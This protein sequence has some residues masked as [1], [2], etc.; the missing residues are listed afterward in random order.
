MNIMLTVLLI[1]MLSSFI[2]AE[3]NTFEEVYKWKV[4]KFK[5]KTETECRSCIP[6]GIKIYNSTKIFVSFPR[7]NTGVPST[8]ALIDTSNPNDKSPL[9]IPWPSLEMNKEGQYD[10][11]LQLVLGFEIM[12]DK[13][14]ALDQG[15]KDNNEQKG[16]KLMIFNI[17]NATLIKKI[18]LTPYVDKDATFLNDIVIHY[19]LKKAFISDSGN[20]I[21]E[22]KPHKPKILII[23]LDKKEDQ[24][25]VIKDQLGS[26]MMPD[27]AF[28]LHVDGNKVKE[29]SPMKTGIDGIAL[30]CDGSTLFYTPLSSRLLY[31]VKTDDLLNSK[32]NTIAYTPHYKKTASDGL[33]ATGKGLLYMT[34]IEDNSIYQTPIA[35]ALTK[36]FDYTK[37]TIYK[38]NKTHMWPDTLSIYDN[39]LYF[40]ANQLNNFLQNKIDFD[41]PDFNFKIHKFL[42]N[43]YSYIEGCN[44]LSNKINIITLVLIIFFIAI[45]LAILIF[46]FCRHKRLNIPREIKEHLVK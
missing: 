17:N 39:H 19:D 9:F 24:V 42:I 41:N 29:D 40:I 21:D 35:N 20:P 7:W 44:W 2:T 32:L 23:D 3:D 16:M 8:L 30:S 46:I 11:S 25:K 34:S 26:T 4:I 22:S 13:L 6:A 38:G 45:V 5:L 31:A 27:A 12:E 10:N 15:V 14:Y 43:D 1:M 33:L 37:F 18:D 28:W 36:P